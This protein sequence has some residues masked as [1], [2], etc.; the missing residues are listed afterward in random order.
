MTVVDIRNAVTDSNVEL[1]EISED[2]I[3]YAEE[4]T[5]EGHYNL[6]LLK[7]DRAS[8]TERI[9]SSFFL[10]DPTMVL[11]FFSFQSDILAVMENGG[12]C[13]GILR[14]DKE[15]G[16]EKNR[17]EIHF[18]GN[19]AD[20]KA[21]DESRVVFYT[22]ENELHKKLFEDYK[23]L[24]GFN[25]IAYLFDL[26]EGRYYYIRDKR[27]CNLSSD[28]LM[29]YD[30]NGQTQLLVLEPYG[31]EKEKEHCYR[32][33]RWLGDHVC[34]N[35]WVCPLIDFVVAVGTDETHLPL[36]LLLSA[37]T[38]GMVRYA[39]MDEENL[40]F[41]AKYFPNNDQRVCAVSRQT[42]KKAVA[43]ELNLKEGEEPAGFFIETSAARIY[44]VTEHEDSYEIDGVLNSS[45]RGQYSKELG[46]FVSCVEDRFLVAKYVISDEKDSFVFYSIYDIE[47][48]KQQSYE[49]RCAVKGNTVVLY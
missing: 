12:S 23:K 30:L 38:Q 31:S 14:V 1:I 49:C 37:G 48:K 13:A 18:V 22:S 21:L 8:K 15:T 33:R 6:F 35:V 42:G 39:G 32:N 10:K 41:R 46:Q 3:Y 11:H 43:A 36:E 47:T 27:I 26:E 5:E 44:R 2:T 17:E 4:K 25:R 29:T 16:K 20:C 28:K 34:D 19:F 40:Y 9:L 45:V 7:Y 24:S